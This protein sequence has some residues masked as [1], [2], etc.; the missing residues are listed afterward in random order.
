MSRI[1]K[2]PI[3]VPAGVEVTING[4]DIKVKGKN[5]ELT[6]TINDAVEVSLNDNVITTAPREVANAWA[7]AGTA[8]A[9]INNMI[10]GVNDGYEK[11]LQLVGVGYRAAVKGNTLDLTLGFSHP[12]NFE[13]PTGITIEAPSQTEIVV[14]GA[15]KQLVGQTAANIRSYREP[16]PYKGKGVRY[17][18]E[19]VRRKEAKK[20]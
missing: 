7:Q 5:G 3:N 15:D 14:K 6:R 1:A 4:Q 12:V 2:A 19:H 18:D 9:L 13:I 11:K 20:K 10:V 17:A 16:E 8:R